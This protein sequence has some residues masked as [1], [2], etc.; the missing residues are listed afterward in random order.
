MTKTQTASEVKKHYD[1]LPAQYFKLN[2]KLYSYNYS[3]L[4]LRQIILAEE[5]G[6]L[7][8]IRIDAFSDDPGI[9][10]SSMN[11]EYKA[12]LASILFVPAPNKKPK[13]FSPNLQ[14]ETREDFFE[15]EN[16]VIMDKIERCLRDFFMRRKKRIIVSTTLMSVGSSDRM[17]SRMMGRVASIY[18]KSHSSGKESSIPGNT[19]DG[20]KS[21]SEAPP[22]SS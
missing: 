2:G 22:S 13:V 10:V 18:S 4:K 19:T 16:P 6:N 21:G 15:T 14:K 11:M 12:D 1:P 8:K 5:T 17:I 3:R 9:P 7:Q 20:S